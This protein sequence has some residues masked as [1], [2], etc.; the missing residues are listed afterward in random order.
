MDPTRGY[1]RI[2]R[3]KP[4]M[5]PTSQVTLIDPSDDEAM[6]DATCPFAI[7]IKV[8]LITPQGTTYFW[9]SPN[10]SGE[11]FRHMFSL[12][13][14]TTETPVDSDG[15]SFT[16]CV[17]PDA[18]HFSLL[19]NDWNMLVVIHDGRMTLFPFEHIESS[20][21]L[22]ELRDKIG[23]QRWW[24]MYGELTDQSLAST[25]LILDHPIATCKLSIPP[26]VLLAASKRANISAVWDSTQAALIFRITG[27]PEAVET[28]TEFWL[29]TFNDDALCQLMQQVFVQMESGRAEIHFQ[30]MPKA[31]LLPM[32][33]LR[34]LMIIAA[35][36][37]IL[38]LMNQNNGTAVTIKRNSHVFWKGC[39][40][41][42]T[43]VLVI[44]AFLEMAY[45]PFH[46]E[47]V[48]RHIHAGKVWYDVKLE[49]LM[50]P[51]NSHFTWCFERLGELVLKSN[52]VLMRRIPLL[53]FF[54]DRDILLSGRLRRLTRS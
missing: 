53:Q 36:R 24:D 7:M 29:T 54:W 3:L 4:D 37:R 14:K 42:D 18:P 27:A 43:S 51:S 32:H 1:L 13:L 2:L 6:E 44:L 20:P 16:L 40:H 28:M 48:V 17:D 39:L 31:F 23:T 15:C 12:K 26:E 38:D 33:L 47:H 30:H 35:A 50:R 8:K 21:V 19:D 49:E 22:S 41:P 46:G 5:L 34:G 45:A 11:F 10:Q 9:I 25:R 52:N